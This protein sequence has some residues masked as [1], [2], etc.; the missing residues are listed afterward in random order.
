MKEIIFFEKKGQKLKDASE[1]RSCVIVNE[2]HKLPDIKILCQEMKQKFI[3]KRKEK[4]V[5]ICMGNTPPPPT[6]QS[7]QFR[8]E[9]L[10]KTIT[11]VSCT[12]KVFGLS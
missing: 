4:K 2:G 7:E 5:F 9:W 3:K 10:C 1:H 6:P 11:P 12:T 8:S